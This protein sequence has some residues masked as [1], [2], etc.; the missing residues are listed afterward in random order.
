M[1]FDY[2]RGF[3]NI[4]MQELKDKLKVFYNEH[5]KP[6]VDKE[7]ILTITTKLEKIYVY[8]FTPKKSKWKLVNQ[9]LVIEVENVK[10]L[11]VAIFLSI[12]SSY[13]SGF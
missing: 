2:L 12:N 11:L 10:L 9:F 7:I 6:L 13:K 1:N 5:Y 3:K 8:F 4:R